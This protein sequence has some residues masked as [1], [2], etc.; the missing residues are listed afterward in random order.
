VLL[1]EDDANTR[2]RLAGT[3]NDHPRL[4][5]AAA[6]GNCADARARFEAPFPNVLL[7]DLGLPDGTGI[8][9]I[10]EMQGLSPETEIMVVTVFGDEQHVLAAIEAGASGYLLKDGS[11]E[12]IGESILQLM[13]GES[14]ISPAIAR[15]LLKRFRVPLPAVAAGDADLPKLTEREQEILKFVAKGFSY[16]EIAG[17]LELSVHTVT[18]H[19]KHIYRKLSVGSRGEAVF[20]AMQLGLIRMDE[21]R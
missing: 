21:K 16:A 6:V 12:Y 13:A 15:H 10:R 18:S 1:V 14:P 8:D 20:E 2:R 4:E 7:T 9:L 5:L 19:I 3:V 11:A 17:M